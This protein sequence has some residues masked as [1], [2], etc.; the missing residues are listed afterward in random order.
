M[1]LAQLINYVQGVEGL[2]T[3]GVSRSSLW[4]TTRLKHLVLQPTC[5]VCGYGLFMEVHHIKPFHLFP[6]LELIQSNL[7]TLG[8]KCPTGN[9]HLL[10]GHLGLWAS[11]NESVVADA[12]FWRGKILNRPK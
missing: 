1:N 8:E 6:D 4:P 11:W 7:I 2:K 3:S 10:F 9:H 5:M 12:G